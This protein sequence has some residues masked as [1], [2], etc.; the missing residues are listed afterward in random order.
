MPLAGNIVI[1][2]C[3]FILGAGFIFY[4][5]NF[6]GCRLCFIQWMYDIRYKWLQGWRHEV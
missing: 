4:L 5:G 2:I 3:G 6:T 1:L